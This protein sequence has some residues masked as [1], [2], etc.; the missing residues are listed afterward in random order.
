MAP[1]DQN[2]MCRAILGYIYT[3]KIRVHIKD[4]TWNL[5]IFSIRN[6]YEFGW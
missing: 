3:L 1:V 4:K 5:I 6:F 2:T